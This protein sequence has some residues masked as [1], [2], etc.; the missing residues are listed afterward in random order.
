MNEYSITLFEACEILNRS[1]KTLSRYIR[2]GRLTP[3][4]ITSQQGTLEY[5][6]SRADLDALKLL[7]DKVWLYR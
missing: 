7:L 5:R 3:Q 1:K 6:F 2:Q 4:R